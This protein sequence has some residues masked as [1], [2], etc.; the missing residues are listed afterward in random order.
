MWPKD[1]KIYEVIIT[2]FRKVII[3][4]Y[5]TRWR[6]GRCLQFARR[7]LRTICTPLW[8]VCAPTVQRVRDLT[9]C[10]RLARLR[11]VVEAETTPLHKRQNILHMQQKRNLFTFSKSSNQITYL[12]T[13]STV[14]K[15]TNI[16]IKNTYVIVFTHLLKAKLFTCN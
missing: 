7:D 8:L 10:C 4:P 12:S 1:V 5:I 16:F 6:E 3:T 11:S 9:T 2:K 13:A 15:N 14:L